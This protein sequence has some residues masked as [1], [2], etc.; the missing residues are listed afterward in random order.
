MLC[1][2]LETNNDKLL[3]LQVIHDALAAQGNNFHVLRRKDIH[4]I[5]EAGTNN[6][7]RLDKAK[8]LADIAKAA[9]ADSV[10]FQMINPWGLYL[11]GKYEYGGYDIE[12][13]LEIRQKGVMDDAEYEALAAYCGDIGISYSASVFDVKALDLL[14]KFNPPYVKIASCDLNH[15]TLIREVAERGVKMVLSTGMSTLADVNRTVAELTRRNVDDF[16][17]LH[18]VSVYPATLSQCNL[19]Y[20]ETLK[21]EFG[22]TVG[23]SDH[24]GTSTAAC[25]ALQFG[26]TWFEKHFTEDQNQ[27]GLDHAYAMEPGGLNAYERDLSMALEALAAPGKDLSDAE[28]HTRERA[29]RALYAARDLPKGHIVTMDDVLIVRPEG[30]MGADEIDQLVGCRLSDDVEQHQSFSRKMITD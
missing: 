6:N 26:A 5:A 19:R 16:V 1:F 9:R 17:L 21:R 23:F 11:P 14:L 13:V 27:E 10:K 30:E 2:R 15:L 18:C 29:R 7:G 24:T 22:C 12:K 28:K 3:V 8:R 4:L 20:I 25:M